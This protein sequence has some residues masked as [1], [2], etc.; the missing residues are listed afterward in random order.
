MSQS[1][2]AVC[3]CLGNYSFNSLPL[4]SWSTTIINKVPFAH[5]MHIEHMVQQPCLYGPVCT[6]CLMWS[7]SRCTPSLPI[8]FFLISNLGLAGIFFYNSTL[9]WNERPDLVMATCA[10]VNLYNTY[11][12]VDVTIHARHFATKLSL[13]GTGVR[14][15]WSCV[16]YLCAT[17]T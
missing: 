17:V 14:R 9:L 6:Q 7:I 16:H 10:A 4:L 2:L 3:A 8:N 13:D 12:I 5:L 1:T 11:T 15:L